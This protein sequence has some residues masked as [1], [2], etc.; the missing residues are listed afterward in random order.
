MVCKLYASPK[1]D[2]FHVSSRSIIKLIDFFMTACT[3]YFGTNPVSLNGKHAI[4]ETDES[5]FRHKQKYYRDRQTIQ[6][7]WVFEMIDI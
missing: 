4:V 1:K 7:M 3:N 2:E 5:L 6:E